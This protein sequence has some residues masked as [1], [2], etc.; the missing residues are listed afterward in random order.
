MSWEYLGEL[1]DRLLYISRYLT[2]KTKD[3]VIVDLDC[4]E[5][6]LLQFIQPDYKQYIGNDKL[7]RFPQQIPRTTFYQIT[8]DKLI[9]KLDQV[10]ILLIIGHGGFEIDGHSQESS[11]LSQTARDIISKFSPKYVVYESV[12]KYQ[13]IAQTIMSKQYSLVHK[14]HLDLGSEWVRQRVIQCY[15]RKND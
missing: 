4:L 2:G 7:D 13:E 11:T 6:R 14:K 8:D 9:P 10:D 1:D 5:A 3:A 15:E 12:E